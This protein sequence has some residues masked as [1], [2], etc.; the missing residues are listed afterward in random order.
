MAQAD[1]H[2]TGDIILFTVGGNSMLAMFKN[3]TLRVSA[4]MQE[5][6]AAQ[7][8]WRYRVPRISQFDVDMSKVAENELAAA[9]LAADFN[10]EVAFALTT[11]STGKKGIVISGNVFVREM[12]LEFPDSDGQNQTFALEGRGQLTFTV[13]AS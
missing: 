10:T 12:S 1:R 9:N 11:A 13:P 4:E 7:D 6:R 2:Y 5:A 3:V 8:G